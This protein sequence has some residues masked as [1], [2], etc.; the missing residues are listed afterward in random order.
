MAEKQTK[1]SF[2]DEH[3]TI[4]RDTKRVHLSNKGSA[5]KDAINSK[6]PNKYQMKR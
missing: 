4:C 1:S 2:R 3:F 5:G 6:I